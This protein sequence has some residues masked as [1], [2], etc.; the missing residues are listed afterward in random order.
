MVLSFHHGCLNEVL[1]L[2]ANEKLAYILGILMQIN[3]LSFFNVS[4][5]LF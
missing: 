3:F 2:P 4:P 5:L 1:H